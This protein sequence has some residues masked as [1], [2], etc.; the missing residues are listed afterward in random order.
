MSRLVF[1][2]L[3]L[4][5]A[6]ALIS[7]FALAGAAMA[8]QGTTSTTSGMD[9]SFGF[10]GFGARVGIVDPERASSTLTFGLHAN[11]GEFLP[12]LRITPMLEYWSVGLGGSDLSDLMV[13][14]NIDWGLPLAGQ[15]VIPY[16][17]GGLGLHRIKEEYQT[18]PDKSVSRL[19]LH[20]QLGFRDQVMPNL[21]LFGEARI[22][23][24]QDTDNWKLLGGFTYNF[25]Y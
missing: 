10:R 8:Q 4:G 23:F 1:R 9:E 21:A 7:V 2:A 13:G 11:M 25:I 5:S 14:T 18:R 20:G 24:V 6:L 15:K 19:G 22:T 3:A 12:N 17:G 16:A